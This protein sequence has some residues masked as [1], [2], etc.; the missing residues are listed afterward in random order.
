MRLGPLG[1]ALAL[2]QACSAATHVESPTASPEPAPGGTP[3]V[4]PSSDAATVD[5]GGADD[6]AN[7]DTPAAEATDDDDEEVLEDEADDSEH[8]QTA[9]EERP[10]PLDGWSDAA[11][12]E[13]VKSDLSSLGSISVGSPSAGLLLNGQQAH[14]NDLYDP[15]SPATA[16]G[17]EE[18]LGYLDAA[19]RKVHE[20]C[21]DSPVL[22]LGDISAEKGGP[23]SPHVSHQAGRDVDI[24]Y[25]YVDGQRWY[26]RGTAQNLDL[27]RNWAFIRALV[28]ETDVEYIFMDRSIQRLL[29]DY[30]LSIGEDK[31]WVEGLFGEGGQR[32]IIR[33]ARGHAT[34]VHVRFYN[35]IAE[36]TARRAY[37]ALVADHIVPPVRSFIHHLIRHGE[38][39]G[40]I[41]RR[42]K[43]SIQSLKRANRIKKSLIREK[44][45]LLIPVVHARTAPPPH[46]LTYPARRL[47]PSDPA[48]ER[49]ASSATP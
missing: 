3:D 46:R 4:S 35:P 37:T 43:V 38:T 27:R 2:L 16:W 19:L 26:R 32:A 1:I 12:A 23:L 47:P 45:T 40:K 22:A 18:T 25:F 7:D 13:A 30:A 42:Y 48:P 39:L 10:H 21:P 17:T 31:A 8:A 28:T 11:V 24:S 44:H 5:E 41:A 9:G 15:V 6:G 36:E 34:H 33:Y 20:T 49:A 29:R 14:Q